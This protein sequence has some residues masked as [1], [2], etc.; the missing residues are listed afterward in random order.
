M[1]NLEHL[2]NKQ[3]T[4]FLKKNIVSTKKMAKRW[5]T[6]RSITLE[7]EVVNIKVA[8]PN[9]F[10]I[11]GSPISTNLTLSPVGNSP[12]ANAAT[13]TGGSVLNLQP[14]DLTHPGVVSTVAQ[15]FGGLKT[16]NDG[17]AI[18]TGP[19][20][21]SSAITGFI[22]CTPTLSTGSITTFHPPNPQYAGY[23][24]G[25]QVKALYI[26][27]FQ[28]DTHTGSPVFLLYN[29]ASL[30]PADFVPFTN[31]HYSIM[32]IDNGAYTPLLLTLGT[33]GIITISKPDQTAFT[34]VFGLGNG[35]SFSYY[36]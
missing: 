24:F 30:L 11:N 31:L 32:G 13:V 4:S 36:A 9:N 27:A 12:N 35:I 19:P 8:T 5:L 23:R 25:T 2:K 29:A 22:P 7:S 15:T 26:Q 1:C 33:T 21:S 34:G 6:Q 3:K 14:A 16:F 18:G 28:V 10:T 20:I 17:I